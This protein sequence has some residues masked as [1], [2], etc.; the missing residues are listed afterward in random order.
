MEA[1]RAYASSAL[2]PGSLLGAVKQNARLADVLD[3]A[4]IPGMEIFSAVANRKVRAQAA[5]PGHPRRLL[6]SGAATDGGGL[7]RRFI[8]P[9]SAT[10]GLPV[11][12]VG[13][14]AH[15][16]DLV[17]LSIGGAARPRKLV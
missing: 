4:F 1:A 12:L 11:V 15:Q 2:P 3:Y 5:C 13:G 16:A 17:V 8:D 14:R 10:H 6:L 7:G 9:V